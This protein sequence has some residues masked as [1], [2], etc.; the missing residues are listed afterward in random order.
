MDIVLTGDEKEQE[1][2][3]MASEQKETVASKNKLRGERRKT[4]QVL[5]GINNNI[6]QAEKTIK[7]NRDYIGRLKAKDCKAFN[8]IK[9]PYAYRT[10]YRCL[11]R[12]YMANRGRDSM[13]DMCAGCTFD[14]AN[15]ESKIVFTKVFKK[16]GIKQESMEAIVRRIVR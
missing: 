8:K 4:Q 11:A 16:P 7:D 1:I 15:I 14:R 2:R 13:F 5:N 10:N 6:Y 12:E 3:R 9:S